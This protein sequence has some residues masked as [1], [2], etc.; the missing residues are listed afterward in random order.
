MATS[1]VALPSTRRYLPS[2]STTK[3]GALLPSN[4]FI[5]GQTVILFP[6]NDTHPDTI[7][8][9]LSTKY[10]IT[11]SSND[12]IAPSPNRQHKWKFNISL[13]PTEEEKRTWPNLR[14]AMTEE[15][16]RLQSILGHEVKIVA[17]GLVVMKVEGR[18]VH[19]EGKGCRM[20]WSDSKGAWTMFQG[21]SDHPFPLRVGVG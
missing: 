18:E 16:E 6:I 8:L 10:P 21:E 12:Y 7:R 4:T 15:H 3:V 14:E 20:M 19:L 9:R 13:G 11:T 17:D 2:S 5:S 1:E